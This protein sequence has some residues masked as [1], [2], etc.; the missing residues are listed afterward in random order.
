MI[1]SM[2]GYGAAKGVS[3]SAGTSNIDISV[4]VK[5]VNN[6]YLDCNIRMPRMFS[7]I[8]DTLK[9]A[10]TRS[11]SRGKVDV[12]VN[13]DTSKADLVSIRLN[14]PLADAYMAALRSLSEAYGLRSDISAAE[15]TRYPDVIQIE[16]T[17]ADTDVLSADIAAV[18]EAALKDF[19]AMRTREGGHLA[20]D[21]EERLNLIEALTKR[22]R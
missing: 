1:K 17:E 6:R 12:Y 10:V 3:G 15:L 2:T 18:L 9:S 16:K 8:E 5:S 11:I 20:A 21:I 7:S 19:D 13:I 4:E 14:K 22:G